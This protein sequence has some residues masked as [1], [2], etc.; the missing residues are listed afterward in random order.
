MAAES[1]GR[2]RCAERSATRGAIQHSWMQLNAVA[3]PFVRSVAAQMH[4]HDDRADFLVAVDLILEGLA[5]LT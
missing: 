4:D 1:S 5:A 3:Y 2:T